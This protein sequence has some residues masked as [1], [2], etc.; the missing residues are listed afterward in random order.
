MGCASDVAFSFFPF[1]LDLR[2][3]FLSLVY[4]ILHVSLCYA[5]DIDSFKVFVFFATC[6][7][8]G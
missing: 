1:S 3:V 5:H 6:V 4:P 8:R 7:F 2:A